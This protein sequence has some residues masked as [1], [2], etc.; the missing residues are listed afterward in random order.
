MPYQQKN[1][2]YMK[3]LTVEEA[4]TE[5]GYCVFR[6]DAELDDLVLEEAELPT[7]LRAP[8]IDLTEDQRAELKSSSAKMREFRIFAEPVKSPTCSGSH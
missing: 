2:T 6:Y 4:K 5:K 7:G 3:T 1:D 8:K